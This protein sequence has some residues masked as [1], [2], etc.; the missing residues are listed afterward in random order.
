MAAGH[1]ADTDGVE[2]LLLAAHTWS[3]D[4]AAAEERWEIDGGRVLVG[5][6]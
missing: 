3:V 2:A 5:R 1:R 6:A 4:D